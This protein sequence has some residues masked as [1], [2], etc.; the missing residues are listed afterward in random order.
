MVK[1][2]KQLFGLHDMGIAFDKNCKVT[3]FIRNERFKICIDDVEVF[4]VFGIGL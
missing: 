2:L 3:I 4:N 1:S